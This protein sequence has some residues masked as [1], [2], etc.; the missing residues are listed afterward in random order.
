MFITS[1]RATL[2]AALNTV[3]GITGHEYRPTVLGPGDAWPYLAA[4]DRAVASAWEATW[5][6]WVVLSPDERQSSV[7]TDTLLPDLV[8][9]LD[10]VAYTEQVELVQFDS[11]AGDLFALR[12]RCRGE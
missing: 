11:G 9:A 1:T 4:V 12:I 8:E 7:L 6:V 10:E 5:S 2:A 3:D